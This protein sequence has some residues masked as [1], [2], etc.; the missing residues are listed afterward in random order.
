MSDVF[1][2]VTPCSALTDVSVEGTAS[3]F[4]SKG[5]A[6]KWST[7]DLND[8]MRKIIYRVARFSLRKLSVSFKL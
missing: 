5:K 4:R 6:K 3:I 2:N 8:L 1:C 7:N